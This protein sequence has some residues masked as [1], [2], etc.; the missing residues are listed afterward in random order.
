[1][2]PS[3]NMNLPKPGLTVRSAIVFF[4]LLASIPLHPAILSWDANQ[5]QDISGFIV[6]FGRNP[7]VY[8]D[9]IDVGR[10]ASYE[11]KGLEKGIRYFFAVTSYDS[12]Y[13]ESP[14][15]PELSSICSD[16][17]VSSATGAI[18]P[19][20]LNIQTIASDILLITFDGAL[21]ATTALDTSHYSV[22]GRT[23]LAT[24]LN[25]DGNL[26]LLRIPPCEGGSH[27]LTVSG[28][29]YSNTASNPVAVDTSVT[30]Q[31]D[32]TGVANSGA[33]GPSA[34]GL[35]QNYPNP[36]NPETRMG[37]SVTEAG[38]AVVTVFDLTGRRIRVLFD[39]EIR[40]PGVQ[41]DL[42]WNGTDGAGNP[43]SSG[44]YLVRLQQGRRVDT[45]RM[46]LVR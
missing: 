34:F 32:M 2:G 17:P 33:V 6:Y 21:E 26:V 22:D 4:L 37:F 27:T 7:G 45:R 43:A 31:T 42:V 8:T 10:T 1:M 44:V 15:S 12:C 23:S 5:D 9:T 20:I 24:H 38:P 13:N 41:R 30:Y 28:I 46:Q 40:I 18:A 29:L 16:V 35:S 14:F 11:I 36:F 39:G 3:M 25:S 19:R